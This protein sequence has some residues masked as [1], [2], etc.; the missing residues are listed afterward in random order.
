MNELS[1]EEQLNILH[2]QVQEIDTHLLR[3]ELVTETIIKMLIKAKLFTPEEYQTLYKET[4]DNYVEFR[5]SQSESR[6]N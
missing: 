5:K 6:N 3:Y 1:I 4:V 2:N